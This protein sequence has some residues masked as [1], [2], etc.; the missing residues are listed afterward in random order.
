[1]DRRHGHRCSILVVDD[2]PDL[3]EVVRLALQ[4]EGYDVALAANGREALQHLRS[5]PSTCAIVLDLLMPTMNGLEF[6]MAQL[7]DR[8]L[9]WIPVI[10]MSGSD[11][12]RDAGYDAVEGFVRKP[13]DVDRLCAAVRAVSCQS[14]LATAQRRGADASANNDG[15]SSG[16][17]EEPGGSEGGVQT[18][19]VEA[20]EP[21]A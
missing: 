11:L 6:R 18:K 5:T 4:A 15:H 3:R 14:R 16:S 2:E 1:M 20:S 21:G 9:A 10:V 7:R 19:N 8:S 13:L 17:R 12:G